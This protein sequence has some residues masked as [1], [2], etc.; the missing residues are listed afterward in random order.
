MSRSTIGFLA[1]MPT[2][3]KPLRRRLALD[4]DADGQGM[5]ATHRGRHG[6]RDVVALVTGM[7][8]TRAEDRTRHLLDHHD[9]DHVI[10]IGIAGGIGSHLSIGDLVVPEVVIDLRDGREVVPTPI[11][12]IV[13]AGRLLT[14][15]FFVTDP[16]RLTQFRDEG[17]FAIDMETA[18]IGRVCE[19]EGVPWS[20]F[21]AISD[22]VFDP[23]VDQGVL[24]LNME[25]G[26]P[27]RASLVRFVARDPRRVRLLA[28]L[29]RDLKK[30]TNAA[31]D[32][33]LAATR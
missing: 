4:V 28:R 8:M 18:A 13:P 7:G 1:P 26:S 10:V 32:A 19:D 27:D 11:G 9:I 17:A 23:A 16:R 20:V 29:G 22:D 25:D 33:A 14:G 3:L 6:E 30:A 5:Y 15:A 2:E 31:V 24:A 12:P 21:R